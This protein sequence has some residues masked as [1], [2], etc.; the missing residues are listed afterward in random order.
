[1]GLESGQPGQHV[2]R[3]TTARDSDLVSVHPE[4]TSHDDPNAASTIDSRLIRTHSDRSYLRRRAGSSAGSLRRGDRAAS[5]RS[6]RDGAR[7][8]ESLLQ[9]ADRCAAGSGT[10]PARDVTGE[11]CERAE[12]RAAARVQDPAGRRDE[13]RLNGV[14]RWQCA[15]GVRRR[16]DGEARRVRLELSEG[17]EDGGREVRDGGYVREARG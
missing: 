12:E 8:A 7:V 3:G 10:R 13:G 15:R 2:K 16:E 4:L 11:A 14:R 17:L 5:C 1:M 9:C 6:L